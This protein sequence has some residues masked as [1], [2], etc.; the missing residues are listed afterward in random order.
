MLSY[1]A[2]VVVLEISRNV[3][4]YERNKYCGCCYRI[5]CCAC[6]CFYC[7][8]FVTAFYCELL[9]YTQ[10]CKFVVSIMTWIVTIPPQEPMA[11]DSAA[12]TSDGKLMSVSP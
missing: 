1:G 2:F 8:S 5:T 6:V 10:E 12:Q 3:Y 9:I 7:L 11:R 4:E